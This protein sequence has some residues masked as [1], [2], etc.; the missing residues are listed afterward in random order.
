MYSFNLVLVRCDIFIAQGILHGM[1]KKLLILLLL[2][3][4]CTKDKAITLTV[5]SCNL[6]FVKVREQ[7]PVLQKKH[8]GLYLQIKENDIGSDELKGLLIDAQQR[9][10]KVLIWP[11]LRVEQGPWACE[12]N[13]KIFGELIDTLIDWMGKVPVTPEYIVI[14]ME[15]S[16]AQMDTIKPHLTHK[17]YRAIIRI[18]QNNRDRSKF[19]EAVE[20]YKKIVNGIHKKGFKVMI[21][22]YPFI[23]DDFHD[24]DPDIQDIANV[25][26][27]GIDW[28][29]YTFTPYRTAY[30]GDLGVTFTPYMVYEYGKAAGKR[31]REKARLAL[32]IIGPNEHGPGYSSPEDLAKDIA[33]A[34]AAGIEEIDLFHLRGMISEG[35]IENWINADVKAA[36]PA[37]DIK[38]FAA[39]TFLKTLDNVLDNR[40]NAKQLEKI[41]MVIDSLRA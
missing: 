28:D 10:I 11:L 39:R 15:N 23:I 29:A 14:N 31:F 12:N 18:L 25:P 32:G 8:A 33:A 21:T 17:E 36:K 6:S 16:I 3:F 9:G 27:S 22:T 35:A 40:D 20:G 30:S 37:Y 41:I 4:S 24:D 1:N 13:Y 2:L 5:K 19:N 38:V 34:K 7:L 26:V